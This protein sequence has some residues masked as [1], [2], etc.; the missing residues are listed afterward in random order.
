MG[1][2]HKWHADA[3]ERDSMKWRHA[4]VLVL[5]DTAAVIWLTSYDPTLIIYSIDNPNFLM[6]P[7]ATLGHPVPGRSFIAMR[8]PRQFFGNR[9]K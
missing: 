9:L 4:A 2:T 5:A 3:L 6:V 1:M 8:R 7:F